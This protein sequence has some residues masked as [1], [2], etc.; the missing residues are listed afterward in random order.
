MHTKTLSF[1]HL[2]RVTICGLLSCLLFTACS[3][4]PQ[5]PG[6]GFNE[7]PPP[8]GPPSNW[9]TPKAQ[10]GSAAT[11]FVYF[12]NLGRIEQ[13]CI[14]SIP[15]QKCENMA[16]SL[17]LAE[18]GLSVTGATRADDYGDTKK[19]TIAMEGPRGVDVFIEVTVA[20]DKNQILEARILP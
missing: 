4:A 16:R 20:N 11:V 19:V 17:N 1:S 5:S 12:V 13:A 6:A 9:A 2:I 14:M 10:A 7:P 18:K 8:P 15:P 3:T